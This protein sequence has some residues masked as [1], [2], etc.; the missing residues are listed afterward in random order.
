MHIRLKN[1]FLY[2][3]DYKIKCAIGKRG[4]A[5]KKIEGDLRTPRGKYKFLMLLY[6][7]DRI[8]K[9][10][11]KIKKIMIK[12]NMGWCDDSNST[13]Y[14]RMI[15]FPF[16]ASAEKLY[17]KKSIYDLILVLNYNYSPVKKNRGSAIFLHVASKNY[18]ST[19]GCIAIK[20]ED[21]IKL[22][23]QINKKTFIYI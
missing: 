2:F 22:L 1:N 23:S 19:K 4:L 8:K 5:K 20:K 10:V 17:L 6:R 13:Y 3:K 18:S 11:S 16:K 7:K 15:N 9:L 14:N 12:K 21:L